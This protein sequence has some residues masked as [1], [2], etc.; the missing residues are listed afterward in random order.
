MIKK[1]NEY[2]LNEELENGKDLNKLEKFYKRMKEIVNYDEDEYDQGDEPTRSD[3][4]SE[5]GDL[6]DELSLTTDDLQY[7]VDKH[8]NDID[9]EWYVKPQLQ[10]ELGLLSEN[11]KIINIMK[12]YGVTEIDAFIKELESALGEKIINKI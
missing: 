3:L 2:S 1:F 10:Y 9:V 4:A 5:V 11:E 7:I 8:L 6:M 12:K